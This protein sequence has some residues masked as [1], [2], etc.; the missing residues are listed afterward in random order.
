MEQMSTGCVNIAILKQS[1]KNSVANALIARWARDADRS[2]AAN[3][4]NQAVS[5]RFLLGRSLVRALVERTTD[6]NGQDFQIRSNVNGKPFV[7]LDSGKHGPAISVSHSGALI[8]A[9]ATTL[10]SLGVDVENHQKKR[11]FEAIASFAFGPQERQAASMSSQAFYRIWCLREAMSKASGKGLPEVTDRIDRVLGGPGVGTW[12][13]ECGSSRWLLAHIAPA[14]GYSLAVAVKCS[15][16]A[17]A[18]TWSENSL[19]LWHPSQAEL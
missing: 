16:P 17:T 15:E 3:L 10:G 8:V 18:I 12:E 11:S 4:G 2:Q 7:R 19:D 14:A 13:A 5:Q 1:A 6:T 9:A